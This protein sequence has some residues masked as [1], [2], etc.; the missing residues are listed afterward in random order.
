MNKKVILIIIIFTLFLI[1]CI[2]VYNPATGRKETYLFDEKYEINLGNTIAKQIIS[3]TK[4]IDDPQALAYLREIGEKLAVASHRGY[5]NYKFYIVDSEEINAFALLG[6]HIFVNKGL[7]DTVSET[8][9]AFVIGHEVG[10]ICARHGLKRFQV[11]FGL[12]LVMAALSTQSDQKAIGNLI[13]EVD[14]YVSLGFSRKDEYQADALGVTYAYQAGYD[15]KAALTT[16]KRFEEIEKESGSTTM[17]VFLRSHPK[18]KNRYAEAN[19]K[20]KEL[21]STNAT[22]SSS[23]IK[24]F[25]KRSSK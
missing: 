16:F 25:R 24:K 2:T 3:Q 21:M 11:A 5:L 8:E 9:L 1:G 6:G 7:I 14:K 10:H 13:S 4:M 20:I 15:P 22:D 23:K 12:Q 19:I 18:P 17:P